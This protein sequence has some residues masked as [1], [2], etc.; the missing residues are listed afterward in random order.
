MNEY[1]FQQV[2]EDNFDEFGDLD[3]DNDDVEY[4]VD[5]DYPDAEFD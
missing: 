3:S 1:D 2:L 4:E 5:Y